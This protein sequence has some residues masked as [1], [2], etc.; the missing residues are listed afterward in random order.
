MNRELFAEHC[1]LVFC[2]A[3]FV[4]FSRFLI[5]CAWKKKR[6][7]NLNYLWFFFANIIREVLP[8]RKYSDHALWVGSIYSADYQWWLWKE[9]WLWH[10]LGGGGGTMWWHWRMYRH[11]LHSGGTVWWHH[12]VARELL[13]PRMVVAHW[14]QGML[15]RVDQEIFPAMATPKFTAFI[16]VKMEFIEKI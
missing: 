10:K 16:Y 13:P 3:Q 2:A 8:G 11:M 7:K 15:S 6:R 14:A 9:S 1:L 5:L 12:M 4:L